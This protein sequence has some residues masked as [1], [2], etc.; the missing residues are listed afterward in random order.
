MTRH[1]RKGAAEQPSVTAR[2]LVESRAAKKNISPCRL[3]RGNR[4]LSETNLLK[5]KSSAKSAAVE[6][7]DLLHA[8]Q[9]SPVG[10]LK[11]MMTTWRDRKMVMAPC[12]SKKRSRSSSLQS[13]HAEAY[14]LET[15]ALFPSSLVKLML[16]FSL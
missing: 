1:P 6:A 2:E 13:S 12:W 7:L 8:A 4:K 11:A 16:N 3:L 10:F 14:S 5:R 15:V 9:H